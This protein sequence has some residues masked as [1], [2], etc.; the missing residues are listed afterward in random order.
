MEGVKVLAFFGDL[1]NTPEHDEIVPVF[2]ESMSIATVR[3]L[4][5]L[6]HFGPLTIVEIELPNV[7]Q[8]FIIVVMAVVDIQGLLIDA[9]HP[10]SDSGRRKFLVVLLIRFQFEIACLETGPP[11][12]SDVVFPEVIAL[13][14]IHVPAKNIH[15]SIFLVKACGV[16]VPFFAASFYV[17]FYL[18]G[19]TLIFGI[20]LIANFL[21]V[22]AKVLLRPS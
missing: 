7:V 10:R 1:E 3:D 20:R 17:V 14:T 2:D 4:A 6:L 11:L 15:D 21:D 12:K 5:V 19:A 13:V 22:R 8:L 18:D 16:V 9:N